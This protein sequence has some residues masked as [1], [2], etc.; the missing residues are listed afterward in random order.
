MIILR[1]R[2]YSDKKNNHSAEIATGLV[3]LGGTAALGI[4][5]YKKNVE[6][7]KDSIKFINNRIDSAKDIIHEVND[8]IRQKG[9]YDTIHYDR[10]RYPINPD[11]P[12]WNGKYQIKKFK[13]KHYRATYRPDS[14]L[15][16]LERAEDS[17][18]RY[19][20]IKSRTK[21]SARNNKK[22]EHELD[23]AEKRAKKALEYFEKDKKVHSELKKAG[24]KKVGII[25]ASG[26]A[27]TA[28]SIAGI[29]AY[30]KHK[31]DKEK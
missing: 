7:H 27:L 14:G 25:G 13:N 18:A 11:Y 26:T 31:K 5:E 8:E 22:A 10:I 17:M 9:G 6:P 3:G 2:L 21:R 28:A 15:G 20:S 16:Q 12:D 24:L 30:K 4:H 1:Q 19:D 29:H 23:K